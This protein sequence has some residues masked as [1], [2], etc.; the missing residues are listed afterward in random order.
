MANRVLP[1]FLTPLEVAEMFGAAEASPRDCMLLKC[2]YFLGLRNSEAMNLN[3]EDIDT[4]NKTVKVI[5]GKGRK[6]RYVP[7]PG[8]F[9]GELRLFIGGRKGLLF[10]GRGGKGN[11]SDRHIRRIVKFYAQKANVRKYEEV[12][13]H[14]LR[15]SYATHLQNSGVPLNVIQNLLGHA[16]LET[17]A[18][19][20][21]MGLD[22]AR[23]FV[24]TAFGSQQS[25]GSGPDRQ[26]P[27]GRRQE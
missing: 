27:S 6:D 20:T 9:A 25:A 17:T 10:A 18:I 12:H 3:T 23:E 1:R 11:L 7:V 24:E 19:Y 8:D 5:Q 14:T 15:H 4:M 16:R 21:H 26:A 13:P 22:K 2:L